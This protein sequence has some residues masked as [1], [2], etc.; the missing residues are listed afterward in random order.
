M[1]NKLQKLNEPIR[2]NILIRSKEVLTPGPPNLRVN[3]TIA[4][5][6]SLNNR[7]LALQDSLH[8]AIRCCTNGLKKASHVQI[9]KYSTS[10]MPRRNSNQF[11]KDIIVGNF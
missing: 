4:V 1:R 9:N 2:E 11:P 5:Q 8:K 10:T 7:V 6:Q 3:K